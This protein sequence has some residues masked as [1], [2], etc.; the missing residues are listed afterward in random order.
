MDNFE[1]DDVLPNDGTYFFPREPADQAVGRKKEKAKTLEGLAILKVIVAHL[2][3]K[4]EFFE[5]HS[6]IPNEVRTSPKKFVIMS[7]SYT[8]TA[9]NLRD[10]KEYIE[11]LLD[12]HA[13]NL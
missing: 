12:T 4:I 6:S 13:P 2:E 11:S 9:S 7:N 5:K 8:M 3:E 10:E 1:Q